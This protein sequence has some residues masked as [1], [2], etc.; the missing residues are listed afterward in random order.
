M[1]AVN[2][3]AS[4]A[5]RF[6][7]WRGGW[8]VA[9]R[10]ARRDVRRHRGRSLLV[11][12]MVGLP[13]LLLTAGSTL[14]FTND[15]DTAE[16]L[17]FQLGRT[18]AFISPPGPQQLRQSV[19]PSSGMGWDDEPPSALPLS[20]WDADSGS[21]TAEPALERLLGAEL[22]ALTS[23]P[24]TA[25]VDGRHS[26]AIVLSADLSRPEVLAPRLTLESG[27]WPADPAE[28]LVTVQGQER[29]LPTSGTLNLTTEGPRGATG[30]LEV[31]VVGTAR[32]YDTRFAEHVEPVDIVTAEHPEGLWAGNEWAGRQWLVDRPEP[33]SWADV[34]L[35]NRHG[36]S[37]YSRYVALHPETAAVSLGDETRAN[38]VRFVVGAS[39]LGLLILTT[40]LAGPAFAVS[41]ARQR[42]SLALASSNG[43][44][45][46]QLRRTV[47]AQ[48][49]VL[50]VFSAL[51]GAALGVASGLGAVAAVRVVRPD[52]VYGPI[53]VPW[54]A[55]A[56]V[57]VAAV[58]SSVV[59]ALVP[60][61]GLGRL[62]IVAVLRGQSVS[63]RLRR[64][65]PATGAVLTGLGTA[66]VTWTSFGQASYSYLVFLSGCVLLVIGALML[67]PL[68][69]ASVARFAHRLP[70]PLRVAAR[71]AGR[72]RGRATPT[73]AAIMAGA[74]VLAVVAVALQA[75]TARQARNH[76]QL[77]P[78]GQAV[79]QSGI[80]RLD[81][82]LADTLEQAAPEVSAVSLHRL[83]DY[84]SS[85][86]TTLLVAQRPGCTLVQTTA[87]MDGPGP[88]QEPSAA[89]LTAASDAQLQSSSLAAA[90][91]EDLD[92][93]LDLT[94]DQRSAL[95]TGALAVV[96]PESV[97]EL[98][99]PSFMWEPRPTIDLHRPVD[100]DAEDGRVTFASF[101]EE[102]GEGDLPISPSAGDVTYVGLPV[103]HLS[104]EQWMRLV[105]DW[106]GGPAG[107]LTTDTAVRL[108]ASL[109]VQAV[110]LRTPGGISEELESRL[111]DVL[112]STSA[113][114]TVQVERGFQRDDA[115]A[116]LIVFGVIGLVILVATL[117]ATALSQAENAPLLGTLAAV[118][119]TKRTRR[120]LAGAQALYLGL[121]GSA[122]GLAV[123]LVP[124]AALAR[125]L[126]TTYPDDG[127]VLP[128]SALDIPWLQVV[129][130][131]LTVPLV[132][133]GLAWISIRR[134]PVVTRRAT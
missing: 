8:R 31:K 97:R 17:P 83:T 36:V 131:L 4:G 84:E 3:P 15:L 76:V 58:V 60:S 32:A 134:A 87:R 64:R 47:L 62:D 112:R 82:Q 49:L 98:A 93:F 46:A 120:A 123:G 67:V 73:V 115:L 119:A 55:V 21:L 91:L 89:C 132:A 7:S 103:V 113:D 52:L 43:A 111:D 99:K 75:D 10:M 11:V 106:Y 108:G 107:L 78:P 16:R 28:V 69:L 26:M 79:V 86:P 35:L 77:V 92:R 20:G 105:V 66:A 100:V 128:P 124:G 116:L 51:V 71:E 38:L 40:L 127:H 110:L 126:L 114:T 5:G 96:D 65:V 50:G 125:M 13:V 68:A 45:T 18:Q 94:P 118:G 22:Y 61:R 24:V 44:T 12:I 109:Q 63:P 25:E 70:L 133:G 122:I 95:A 37:A 30:A 101:V 27:R 88:D 19:D 29:G 102:R 39:G 72:Q 34:E 48:A 129:L 41:A 90:N 74:A 80:G 121:L 42:R 1:A 104:H 81:P 14:W 57:A 6:E 2:G 54:P 56:L 59:A 53:E 117:I 9:L 23:G 130:P 33:V 85:T